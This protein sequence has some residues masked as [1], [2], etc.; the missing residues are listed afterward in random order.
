VFDPQRVAQRCDFCGSSSL[1][2]YEQVKEAFRPESLLPFKVSEPQARD[3]IRAW[4]GHVWFAPDKLKSRALT[5]TVHGLYIPYWTFDAQVSADWTAQAGYYYYTT[6]SYRDSKG[7]HQTRQV[8][9]VRWEHA[10]G[11]LDHFFDDTLVP[12]STG[13]AAK[14]LRAVEPFPTKELVPYDAG[15]VSGWVVERYQLDLVGA[16]QHSRAQMDGELR[17]LCAGQVPGDTQRNL[18][19]DADYT[20]QTFK[21]ILTPIWLLTYTYRTKNFQVLINGYTGII[22]GD[23]PKSWIKITL[24]ILAV[25]LII[26]VFAYFA[27]D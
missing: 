23:Y 16:A 22:A 26:A 17:D 20:G 15:F 19:V 6:E 9:H 3:K 27:E 10:A 5:D 21:H 4:F 14:H 24:A 12:A 18:Q 7:N 13:V 1:I 2:P 8:Q 11:H 25:L